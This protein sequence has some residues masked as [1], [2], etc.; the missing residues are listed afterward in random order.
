MRTKIEK[1]PA[2]SNSRKKELMHRRKRVVALYRKGLSC[3]KIAIKLQINAHVVVNDLRAMGKH[4]K[5]QKTKAKRNAALIRERC[6]GKTLSALS[7]KYKISEDRVKELIDNYNKTAKVPVPDFKHLRELRLSKQ[8]S[9]LRLGTSKSKLGTSKS[10]LG[11]SKSKLG[12]SISKLGI[13]K[14]KLGISK[15]KL[16]ISKS[17][18]GISKSKLGTS[19]SKL[20]ISKSKLGTSKLQLGT[21]QSKYGKST[22]KLKTTVIPTTVRLNRI[23]TMRKSGTTVKTIAEKLKLSEARVYQLLKQNIPTLRKSMPKK[24]KK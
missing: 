23:I 17:K 13:S 21:S 9:K 16:G 4:I 8:N 20:G 5:V 10:K 2:A 19:K 1:K 7:R 3:N 6:A 14:S 11:I 18:L 22:R 12:T 15:S 24:R